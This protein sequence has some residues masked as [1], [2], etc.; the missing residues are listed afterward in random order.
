M[1]RALQARGSDTAASHPAALSRPLLSF[2][3]EGLGWLVANEAGP[4][5]AA[6]SPTRWA[7]VRRYRPSLCSSTQNPN[8]PR[9]RLPAPSV[10]R[11]SHARSVPRPRRRGPHL[12][13]PQWEDEIRDCTLPGS[14]RV[15][16]YYADRK[17]VTKE[18]IGAADVV[19]TTYPVVEAEW[20]K[21]INRAMVA[22]EYCGKK[23]LPV[24]RDAQKIL[25]GP[26]RCAPPN[27]PNARRNAT[28]RTKR[29]CA[30]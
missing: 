6:S 24:A 13:L 18:A 12:A 3:E 10:E 19:L 25:L 17:S 26:T 15:L 23:L 9:E 11:R 5:K 1:T 21:I 14:L 30:R 27:W 20:R 22:C 4:I 7:W 8:A 29:R 28:W 2:Q 16:V